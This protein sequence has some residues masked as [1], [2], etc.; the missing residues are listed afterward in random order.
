MAW[1][2][3]AAALT[4]TREPQHLLQKKPKVSST[5]FRGLT[6]CV[7]QADGH[8]V[9]KETAGT[10]LVQQELGQGDSKAQPTRSLVPRGK[11]AE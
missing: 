2:D 9:L 10:A 7:A 4:Q 3:P 1:H 11:E 5:L 6:L 8:Q